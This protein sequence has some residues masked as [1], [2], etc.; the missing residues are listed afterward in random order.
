MPT[1]SFLIRAS[2]FTLVLS[3]YL[4]AGPVSQATS[5]DSGTTSVDS[6][7]DALAD[8]EAGAFRSAIIRL[9]NILQADPDDP[10]AALL[11]GRTY[12]RL[13]IPA[14]AEEALLRARRNGAAESLVM[15]LL[16]DAYVRQRKYDAVFAMMPDDPGT[17]G[18]NADMLA[19]RARAHLELN[20]LDMA[21]RTF[22][23]AVAADPD[24]AQA[25]LGAARVALAR[26][27]F[28][29]A[30]R[31][32]EDAA[33]RRPG[34]AEVWYISGEVARSQGNLAAAV[35]QYDK[36][37]A[38]DGRHWSA[39]L[40]RAATL[41]DLGRDDAAADDLDSIAEAYKN[42]P[43][44]AYLRAMLLARSGDME[45]ARTVLTDAAER[46]GAHDSEQ[47][48]K[49]GPS[50]LLVAMLHYSQG[51]IDEAYGLLDRF[52]RKFP[53]HAGSRQ[54]LGSL[55]LRRGEPDAAIDVLE[56]ARKLAPGDAAVHALLGR[57]HMLA[58]RHAE[59]TRLYARAAELAPDKTAIRTQL[60]LGRLAAGQT[61]E[62]RR[63]LEAV[64]AADPT[65]T[66]AAF[67][68]AQVQI[69]AGD[70]TAALATARNL[71]VRDGASP[72]AH[73]LVGSAQLGLNNLADARAGFEAAVA[74][75]PDYLLARYNLARLD[76]KTGR[77]DAAV[78]R[79]R[80]ILDQHPREVD[81]LSELALAMA[82]VGD[83]EEAENLLKKATAIDADNLRPRLLLLD[84]YLRT[85]RLGDARASA[86]ELVQQFPDSAAVQL[87]MAQV[88]LA[89]GETGKARVSLVRAAD[90][91]GDAVP[92]LMQVARLQLAARDIDGA[93]TTLRRA[94]AAPSRSPVA[95]VPPRAALAEL[96]IVA[97]NTDTAMAIAEALRRDHPALAVGDIAAGDALLRAGRPH[98]AVAAYR[99][100]ETK[101]ALPGLALRLSRALVAAGD[102][103]SGLAVL[104][105]A[106]K[107]HPGAPAVR[108]ALAVA[109]LSA[110]RYPAAITEHEMLL[111]A[112]PDD[113]G[114]LNNLAWLYLQTGDAR[115]LAHAERAY[116]LRPDAPT[117]IDTLGWI[118][119]QQGDPARGLSLLRQAYARGL[120]EGP[121]RYHI[122]EALDKL[123]KRDQARREVEAALRTSK[124]F[125]ERPAA[126]DLF[127]RLSGQ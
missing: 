104:E 28:A 90:R 13:D 72:L 108:R 26:G 30:A 65:A 76:L 125:A 98:D 27:D 3:W 111:Q 42:D 38:Q 99:A 105:K 73:N 94:M 51:K 34:N 89:G 117:V 121:A 70:Y 66:S 20:E 59:A 15:P 80:A 19:V 84:Q 75:D 6:Y 2:I 97:G 81:A 58:G 93:R 37:V 119:V 109:Y 112:A 16:A 85:K 126:Q 127:R 33:A 22:A 107:T 62:A 24:N 44:V 23:A 95:D 31:A 53:H 91:A 100:G 1:T 124:P 77:K 18:Q 12:L 21:E 45:Q 41:I 52:V 122:A 40:S 92:E 116:A 83:T 29:K 8:F 113:A 17:P 7:E 63:D 35:A 102:A 54:V 4:A 55:L 39:R 103:A 88:Q 79:Y 67:L 78:A 43:R 60:A 69:R 110:G 36:A 118:L 123:G 32:A 87:A 57:A 120:P 71:V 5:S 82:S 101:Q 106:V 14:A 64:I 47:V 115:A 46:L 50:L 86:T 48:L 9:K 114:L 56:P 96:E 68:L 10:A 25:V 49:H 61:G 74:A 11:F